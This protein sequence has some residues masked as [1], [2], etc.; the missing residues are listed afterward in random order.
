MLILCD[1]CKKEFDKK[2]SKIKISKNNFCS[3]NCRNNF[4]Q[5]KMF[6]NLCFPY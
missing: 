2:Q 6:Q 5:I 3:I 4:H 1:F